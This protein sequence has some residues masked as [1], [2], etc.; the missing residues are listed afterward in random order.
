MAMQ[1]SNPT[2]HFINFNWLLGSAFTIAP[3]QYGMTIDPTYLARNTSWTP[4]QALASL[5]AEFQIWGGV[6]ETA[7]AAGTPTPWL[8]YSSS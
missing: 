1:I 7:A 5:I 3:R 6:S 2:N 4:A 8:I